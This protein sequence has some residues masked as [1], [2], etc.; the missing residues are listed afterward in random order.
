MFLTQSIVEW[1]PDEMMILGVLMLIGDRI[2]G[3]AKSKGIDPEAVTKNSHEILTYVNNLK[4]V[5]DEMLTLI[6]ALDES[7]HNQIARNEDGTFKWHNQKYLKDKIK[8]IE[9]HIYDMDSKIDAIARDTELLIR[10]RVNR[11]N[12]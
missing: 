12:D 4:E 6:K 9:S 2:M 1:I 10:D 7:H 3:F 8:S 5:N 11:S